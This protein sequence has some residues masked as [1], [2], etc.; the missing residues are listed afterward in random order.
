[1][2]NQDSLNLIPPAKKQTPTCKNPYLILYQDPLDLKPPVRYT[3]TIAGIGLKYSTRILLSSI[4]LHAT[5][6]ICRKLSNKFP[7][8]PQNRSSPVIIRLTNFILTILVSFYLQK[9]HPPAENGL[10]NNLH[11]LKTSSQTEKLHLNPAKTTLN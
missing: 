11:L 6:P 9:R 3:P 5:T 10:L 8:D 1:M 2:I 7:L 4:H